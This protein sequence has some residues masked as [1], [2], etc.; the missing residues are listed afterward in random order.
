MTW[1]TKKLGEILKGTKRER[2][3]VF[4]FIVFLDGNDES[5]FIGAVLTRSTRYKDNLLMDEGHFRKFDDN[6]RKYEFQ[7]D[8]THLVKGRFI[9]LKDWGP[10]ERIESSLKKELNLLNL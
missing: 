1:Q 5:T 7:Y 2:D 3:T 8:N 4:H 9:K 10:F 6:G